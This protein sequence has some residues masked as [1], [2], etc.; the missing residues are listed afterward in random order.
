MRWTVGGEVLES[1]W[2]L[3][4]AGLDEPEVAV[5]LESPKDILQVAEVF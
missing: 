3:A 1:S 4:D 5:V 2:S